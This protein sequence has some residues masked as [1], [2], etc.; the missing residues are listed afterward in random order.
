MSELKT[1]KEMRRIWF[2]E[3]EE[4][5]N[6][7]CAEADKP[8]SINWAT[9]GRKWVEEEQLK[10]EAK[11]WIK[12]LNET[13]EKACEKQTDGYYNDAELEIEGVNYTASAF[14]D[15]ETKPIIKFINQFF[16]LENE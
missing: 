13:L 9:D 15:D 14:E 8:V 5:V 11:N 2:D 10:E 12:K 4:S 6:N 1:L 16:N 7:M 3:H